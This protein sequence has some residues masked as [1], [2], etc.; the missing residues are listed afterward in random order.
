MCVR[1]VAGDA[2]NALDTSVD[3][4]VTAEPAVIDYATASAAF[5]T[6]PLPWDRSYLLLARSAG[7]LPDG[8]GAAHPWRVVRPPDAALAALARDAVRVRARPAGHP[9]GDPAACVP[10]RARPAAGVPGAYDRAGPERGE[11]TDRG[12]GVAGSPGLHRATARRIAYPADDAAARALAER[13][14]ALALDPRRPD[15]AWLADAVPELTRDGG[16]V[17]AA[18]LPAPAF[19]AALRA[20]R[21]AAYVLPVE[22]GP[23]TGPCDAFDEVAGRVPWLDRAAGDGGIAAA[24][25]AARGRGVATIVPLLETRRTLIIRRGIG[26]VVVDGGG[27]LL[28]DGLRRAAE[29]HARDGGVDRRHEGVGAAAATDRRT[30][31]AGA[32]P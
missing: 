24:P 9:F 32:V 19:A 22:R 8:A 25:I 2:R 7:T 23:A 14:V 3:L 16:R 1:V 28:L 18:G 15:A 4:L 27:V 31:S 20:G 17:V 10:P 13:L 21:D 11:R 30:G 5:L 12:G 6:V 29:P 26:G